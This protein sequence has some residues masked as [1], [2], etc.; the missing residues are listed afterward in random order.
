MKYRY[1]L[2]WTIHQQVEDRTNHDYLNGRK[3]DTAILGLQLAEYEAFLSDYQ[4]ECQRDLQSQSIWDP[5]KSE[6]RKGR[7]HLKNRPS[8]SAR[9]VTPRSWLISKDHIDE[10]KLVNGAFPQVDLAVITENV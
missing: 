3:S 5:E 2:I 8:V 1:R 4:Y 10:A 6:F 7:W 9:P